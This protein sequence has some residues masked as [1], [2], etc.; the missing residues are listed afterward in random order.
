MPPR[1]RTRTPY[2]REMHPLSR[3]CGSGIF[4]RF[5]TASC[6]HRQGPK[7]KAGLLATHSVPT[8]SW[9]SFHDA[10]TTGDVD[11]PTYESPASVRSCEEKLCAT[12]WDLD[13]TRKQ[14]DLDKSAIPESAISKTSSQPSMNPTTIVEDILQRYRQLWVQ[15]Q[16]MD[17]SKSWSQDHS[18]FGRYIWE[19]FSCLP[20]EFL[21]HCVKRSFES[22]L[23]FA[24]ETPQA[25]DVAVVACWQAMQLVPGGLGRA[26]FLRW[27]D[28]LPIVPQP[29]NPVLGNVNFMSRQS[30]V[31]KT[32]LTKRCT[33]IVTASIISR[34]IALGILN[35]S[36]PIVK[37]C[38]AN[39]LI[40]LEGGLQT[41]D[42]DFVAACIYA[43]GCAEQFL[44]GNLPR[45]LENTAS[46]HRA[47]TG[48]WRCHVNFLVY[49]PYHV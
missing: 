6:K 30:G 13:V 24:M 23:L 19:P 11:V 1:K 2:L 20:P 36:N 37:Q 34:C 40:C 38:E 44:S 3:F 33:R 25:I 32:S 29:I 43:R 26:A 16:S 35:E 21:D 4:S 15:T 46:I 7:S 8:E 27:L 49:Q 14:N 31:F 10:G 9:P 17:L 5:L 48:D 28:G 18:A 47:V 22:L 39:E 45:F 42:V 41:N 12:T